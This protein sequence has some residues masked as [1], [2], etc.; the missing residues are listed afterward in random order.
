[1]FAD[2]LFIALACTICRFSSLQVGDDVYRIWWYQEWIC[3]IHPKKRIIIIEFYDIAWCSRYRNFLMWDK[4][5]RHYGIHHN[6]TLCHARRFHSP[7]TL[8]S[9]L[10]SDSSKSEVIHRFACRSSTLPTTAVYIFIALHKGRQ[11]FLV[12]KIVKRV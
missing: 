3:R 1:M 5:M 7:G 12:R 9:D 8:L 11:H 2:N 6:S 10:F 4:G